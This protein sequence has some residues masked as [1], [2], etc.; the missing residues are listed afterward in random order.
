MTEKLIIGIDIGGT[1]VAGG[2][3]RNKGQLFKSITVPTRAAEGFGKSM[4]QVM[5]LIE[6][7]VSHAGGR[8]FIAGIGLCAP[9]LLNSHAGL[10][11]NA[12]NLP[13]WKN[14]NLTKLLEKRFKLPTRVENDANAAGLAEVLFGTAVGYRAVF[15][16]T[17]S[18]GIGTGIILDK[19]IYHGKNG[20]AGEGGHISID[21]NSPYRCVCGSMGCIDALAS[22]P[23]M[24]RRTRVKLEQEHTLPSLLRE[25]T[26]NHLR[27]ITPELIGETAKAGDAVSNSIIEETGFLLGV[28]L[29]GIGTVLDPDAVV[30][31]GGVSHIGKPL[32]DKISETIPQFTINRR[33]AKNTPL[34]PAKL[35]SDVGI[36]GA[37]SLFL[38]EGE[39]AKEI[40]SDA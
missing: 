39:L 16:V 2:L 4:S 37:A 15:Y 14:I 28:W 32:F 10:I 9:G 40:K 35:Q 38:Q 8:D 33:F 17:I 7:L 25:H 27:R 36:F 5:M 19:R 18:T 22:G 13:G 31:G 24:V 12:P 1:K 6:S 11:I 34:L 26:R 30:I 20:F 29:A 21:F 3:V 23:A